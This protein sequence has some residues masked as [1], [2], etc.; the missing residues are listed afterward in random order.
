M[1]ITLPDNLLTTLLDVALHIGL[2]VL[3]VI[4]GRWLARRSRSWL[5]EVLIRATLTPSMMS[6]FEAMVYYGVWI[7]TL[8][9][10]LI[11]MGVPATA[12][13]AVV[14]VALLLVGVALQQSLRDLAAA[15]NFLLF[16]PFQVGDLIETKG[17]SGTVEEIQLF[18]TAL[19]CWDNRVV[20]L[21]NAEIQQAGI[22]NYSKKEVLRTDVEVRISYA[23]DV[24]QARRLIEELMAGDARILPEPPAQVLVTKLGETGVNLNVRAAVT[25]REYWAVQSFLREEINHRFQ[26]AG[27]TIPSVSQALNVLQASAPP[28]SDDSF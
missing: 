16:K 4:G 1:Q 11:V 10:A 13:V 26:E 6:L 17:V 14:G 28:V 12:V 5:R 3:V 18:Y 9:A 24:A 7:L 8:M 19:L 25:F 21:P 20:I 2:A 15:V 22:T 23:D 27:I